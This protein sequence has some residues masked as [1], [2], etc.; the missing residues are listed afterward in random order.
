[1]TKELILNS[2]RCLR[3]M[4]YLAKRG[5]P[6]LECHD[7]DYPEESVYKRLFKLKTLCTIRDL[8]ASL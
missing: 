7:W 5:L 8:Y 2:K 4:Q 3:V 6:S 1:M